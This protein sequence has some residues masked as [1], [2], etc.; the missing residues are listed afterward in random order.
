MIRENTICHSTVRAGSSL[1]SRSAG[2]F[3]ASLVI[4]TIFSRS[5]VRNENG[6]TCRHRKTQLTRSHN[7]VTVSRKTHQIYILIKDYRRMI[8]LEH[9]Y[10]IYFVFKKTYMFIDF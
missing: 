6:N 1:R 5:S 2:I 8:H 4:L 9:L 3:L 10:N 7:C